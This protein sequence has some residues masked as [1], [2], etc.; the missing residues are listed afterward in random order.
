[1]V[2]TRKD[3]DFPASSV[4]LPECRFHFYGGF[5]GGDS[6]PTRWSSCKSTSGSQGIRNLWPGDAAFHGKP[7][8]DLPTGQRVAQNFS[9]FTYMTWMV[10]LPIHEW[11]ICMVNVG[12]YTSPMDLMGNERI[13]KMFDGLSPSQTCWSSFLFLGGRVL[14]HSA[15]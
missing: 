6:W 3:G 9:L 13:V 10:D 11:L 4:S 14:G 12:E 15:L 7:V 2:F 5:V 8:S 1:M